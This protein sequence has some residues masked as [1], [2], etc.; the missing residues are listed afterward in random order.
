[1]WIGM[2]PISNGYAAIC[3]LQGITDPI[4]QIIENV[5]NGTEDV[6]VPLPT[7]RQIDRAEQTRGEL[8]FDNP[9]A[10][11]TGGWGILV[12]LYQVHIAWHTLALCLCQ[13]HEYDR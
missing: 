4:F 9:P 8:L 10:P 11:G 13:V 12:C 3:R 5:L 7:P 1:M 6:E 2:Y